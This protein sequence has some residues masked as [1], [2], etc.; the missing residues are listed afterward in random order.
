MGRV[1]RERRVIGVRFMAKKGDSGVSGWEIV[2]WE[3]GGF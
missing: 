2:I 1:G 3:Y